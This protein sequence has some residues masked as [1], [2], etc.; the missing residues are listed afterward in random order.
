MT[1]SFQLETINFVGGDAKWS[2]HETLREAID[3]AQELLSED[4]TQAT[5][6]RVYPGGYKKARVFIFDKNVGRDYKAKFPLA[7]DA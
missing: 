1:I 7:P 3:R 4:R 6:Y 5:I 2:T